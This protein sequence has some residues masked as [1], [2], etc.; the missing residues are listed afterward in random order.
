MVVKIYGHPTS[1]CTQ[2]VL[3][4][5]EELGAPYELCLIDMP[6][7]E[8]KVRLKQTS[9]MLLSLMTPSPYTHLG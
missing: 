5:L 6:K 7:G 9:S 3:F 1:T 8:H 4:T 2:R